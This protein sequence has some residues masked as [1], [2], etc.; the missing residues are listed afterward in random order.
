MQFPKGCVRLFPVCGRS[1]YVVGDELFF[2][3]SAERAENSQINNKT[4]A[5]V[6]I[7]WNCL[8]VRNILFCCSDERKFVLVSAFVSLSSLATSPK[9]IVAAIGCRISQWWRPYA[10][11]NMTHYL[12][13]YRCPL[14]WSCNDQA[15]Q[16]LDY[17]LSIAGSKAKVLIFFSYWAR[18]ELLF[19]CS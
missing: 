6:Q 11:H 9:M 4:S 18:I 13:Q 8:G 2:H 17:E 3:N 15:V 1:Q 10:W 5:D 16:I 19:S 7:R 14:A 12:V